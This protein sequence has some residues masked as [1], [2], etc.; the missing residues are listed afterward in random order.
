L[1]KLIVDLFTSK[2]FMLRKDDYPYAI[3]AMFAKYRI[4]QVSMLRLA[5]RRDKAKDAFGF[6]RGTIIVE[7]M[8]RL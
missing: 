3:E 8:I 1:E 5:R 4:D 7:L 6:L 2:H